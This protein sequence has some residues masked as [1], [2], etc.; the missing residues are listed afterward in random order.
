MSR[1]TS[2]DATR[3]SAPSHRLNVSNAEAPGSHVGGTRSAPDDR[4]NSAKASNRRKVMKRP[5][6]TEEAAL[7][8]IGGPE[9]TAAQPFEQDAG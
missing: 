9:A 2:T 6:S 5:S 7:G 8:S 1:T 4:A 3:W